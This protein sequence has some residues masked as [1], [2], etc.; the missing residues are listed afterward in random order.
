MPSWFVIVVRSPCTGLSLR[1]DVTS[2]SAVMEMCVDNPRSGFADLFA[3]H[4]SID[5]RVAALVEF[6]GGH[7]PGPLELPPPDEPAEEQDAPVD[8]TERESPKPFLP[9]RPPITLG[10]TPPG[11]G[12][13]PWGP[14]RGN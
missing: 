2:T 11:H 8:E 13:G 10:E 12:S 5:R 3:T 6:A 1:V 7:D 4:P 9:D 14:H